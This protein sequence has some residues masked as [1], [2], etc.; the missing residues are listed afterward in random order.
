MKHWILPGI[1][2]VFA[3]ILLSACGSAKNSAAGA[4]E[5]YLNGLVTNNVDAVVS[6]SCGDWEEQ[7]RLEADSFTAV[8][9]KLN[10][11]TCSESG[12]DGE[13]TLVSCKGEIIATY[14]NE[15]QTIS[16]EGKIY[17][18]IQEQSDWR[19]CGYK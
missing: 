17:K 10:N 14:G 15:D 13:F 19:M 16:L 7:G 8:S 5:S 6:A 3:V 4:V 9:A 12:K 1:F 11:L 18:V 2:L